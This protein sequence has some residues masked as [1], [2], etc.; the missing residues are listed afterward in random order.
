MATHGF[1]DESRRGA[2]YLMTMV[3]V[4]AGSLDAARRGVGGVVPRGSR[5]THL[6]AENDG[7]RRQILRAYGGLGHIDAHIAVAAYHGGDDQAPRDRCLSALVTTCC[8]LGV[9][10]LTLDTRLPDRDRL[11][12]RTIAAVLRDLAPFELAYVHCG[13]RDESLLSLPDAIGWAWGAGGEWRRLV[14]PL[15]GSVARMP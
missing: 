13:S 6:S 12:R 15:V 7:R 8:R 9:V 11:D 10:R 3:V 5:R 2:T 14:Q 4:P 1:A